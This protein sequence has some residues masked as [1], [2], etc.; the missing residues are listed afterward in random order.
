MK[1]SCITASSIQVCIFCRSRSPQARS[2]RKYARCSTE[3]RKSAAVD[4]AFGDHCTVN[5]LDALKLPDVAVMVV[6]PVLTDEAKPV[7]LMVATLVFDEVQLTSL[8][9]S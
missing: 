6:V 1:P 3:A 5:K 9:M 7:L 2:H 8:E 4:R